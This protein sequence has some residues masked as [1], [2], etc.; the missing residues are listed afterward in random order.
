MIHTLLHVHTDCKAERHVGGVG[1]VL[2]LSQGWALT[3]IPYTNTKSNIIIEIAA[4]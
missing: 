2:I 3:Q 1:E 4:S